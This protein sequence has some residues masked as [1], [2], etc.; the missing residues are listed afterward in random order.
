MG[1]VDFGYNLLEELVVW[2]LQDLLLSHIM[3]HLDFGHNLLEALVLLVMILVFLQYHIT[4]HLDSGHN[5]LLVV[6][7]QVLVLFL[8]GPESLVYNYLERLV[9]YSQD[10]ILLVE[11]V[12]HLKVEV[13]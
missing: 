9:L 6:F 3:D 13:R 4:G 12:Q 1:L 7:L 2:E 5:L 11:V 8:V 10:M